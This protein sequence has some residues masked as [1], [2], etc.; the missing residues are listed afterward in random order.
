MWGTHALVKPV[1]LDPAGPLLE[2]LD[3]GALAAGVGHEDPDP[4]GVS[5]SR[6]ACTAYGWKPATTSARVSGS[7][8]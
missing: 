5:S 8:V 2:L 7:T 4:H 3:A 1:L 6:A